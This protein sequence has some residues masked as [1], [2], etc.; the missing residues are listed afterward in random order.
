MKEQSG[1]W[2]LVITVNSPGEVSGWLAPM[3][4]RDPA[5]PGIRLA[6]ANEARASGADGRRMTGD[7][8]QDY[9]TRA[10][11]RLPGNGL[12][13]AL[14]LCQ[15]CGMPGHP[16]PARGGPG[17][18][19]GRNLLPIWFGGK[20]RGGLPRCR[21]AWSFFSG[22]LFY[23]ALLAR[24]LKYPALAYT[25]GVAGWSGS[26][27]RFAVPL[28]PCRGQAAGKRHRQGKDPGGR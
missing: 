13:P 11:E 16:G 21:R 23:A 24:R 14:P 12:C 5:G 1:Q 10:D 3:L 2:E 4:D 9:T 27:A 7:G 28:P 25:E 17:G 20:D 15:R 18:W 26:F 6:D 8:Q 22:D 19:S